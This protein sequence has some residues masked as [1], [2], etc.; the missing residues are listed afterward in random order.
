MGTTMAVEALGWENPDAES[1]KMSSKEAFNVRNPSLNVDG[2][3]E[4]HRRREEECLERSHLQ[5]ARG[6]EHRRRG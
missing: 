4:D 3:G 2:L 6:R 5:A 1:A